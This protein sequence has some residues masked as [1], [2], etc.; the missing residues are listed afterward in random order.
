MSLY[1]PRRGCLLSS[2]QSNLV[3]RPVLS[4]SLASLSETDSQ[5]AAA[6]LHQPCQVETHVTTRYSL[7]LLSWAILQ[8]FPSLYNESSRNTFHFWLVLFLR[9]CS[10]H[11]SRDLRIR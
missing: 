6:L 3:R 5:F 2:L 10:I 4:P 9:Q 8:T 11:S 7:L 1:L